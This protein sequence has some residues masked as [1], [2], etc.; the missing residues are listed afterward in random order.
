MENNIVKIGRK[1]AGIIFL[2]AGI[3]VVVGMYNP[4]I[5]FEVVCALWPLILISLGLEILYYSCKK[6][7]ETKIEFKTIIFLII[8]IGMCILAYIC[9]E[10]LAVFKNEAVIA[11]M[12]GM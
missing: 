5:S 7:V 6:G 1:T 8:I 3:L 10:V 12:R 4:M 11:I 9:N 2:L